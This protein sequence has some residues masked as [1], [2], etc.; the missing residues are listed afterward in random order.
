MSIRN[1]LQR[2]MFMITLCF[3]SFWATIDAYGQTEPCGASA[4]HTMLMRSPGYATMVQQIEDAYQN[5]MGQNGPEAMGGGG[6][7]LGHGKFVVLR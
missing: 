1:S 3:L 2:T 4:Y 5:D 6:V 7:I